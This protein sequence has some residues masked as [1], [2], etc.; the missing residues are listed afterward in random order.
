MRNEVTNLFGAPEAGFLKAANARAA[1]EHFVES[2]G[3]HHDLG[4][5]VEHARQEAEPSQDHHGRYIKRKP[6]HRADWH[7]SARRPEKVVIADRFRESVAAAFRTRLPSS[8]STSV[9]RRP[10]AA[11][12][13]GISPP[14]T[15]SP[16]ARECS[17]HSA[18]CDNRSF[19]SNC[20]TGPSGPERSKARRNQSC[21]SCSR[22][23]RPSSRTKV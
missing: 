12:S 4:K 22:S 1:L 21:A 9:A 6:L 3:R 23:S 18:C 15:A 13:S 20:L 5:R 11:T 7:G 2:A 17:D 16:M 19:S 14:A 8:T 10:G